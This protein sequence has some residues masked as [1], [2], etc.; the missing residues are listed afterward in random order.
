MIYG[1][2]IISEVDTDINSRLLDS[3]IENL[4]SYCNMIYLVCPRE[5]QSMFSEYNKIIVD[6]S[7][8]SG[9]TIFEALKSLEPLS[10]TDSVFITF[11]GVDKQLYS[12]CIQEAKE[13][14]GSLKVWIPCIWSYSSDVVLN[15]YSTS[16]IEVY[17]SQYDEKI[18]TKGYQDCGV[19]YAQSAQTLL[20]GLNEIHDSMFNC[21]S[22]HVRENSSDFHFLDVFNNTLIPARIIDISD[23]NLITFS[24]NKLENKDNKVDK[25]YKLYYNNDEEEKH[26]ER[27]NNK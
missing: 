1:L 20:D 4:S 11:P 9:H 13:N 17:F 14:K 16:L 2:V 23:A 8:G 3:T 12:T 19:V 7:F 25:T 26:F 24:F 22:Y 6:S 15:Q 5:H 18:P 27:I 21:N 10:V